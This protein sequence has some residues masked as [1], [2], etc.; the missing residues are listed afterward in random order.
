M[1]RELTGDGVLQ[2]P[3]IGV[4]GGADRTSIDTADK[5]TR[6]CSCYG[7]LKQVNWLRS[8]LLNQA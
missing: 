7:I 5:A 4:I 2:G 3:G 1:S 8:G 6:R